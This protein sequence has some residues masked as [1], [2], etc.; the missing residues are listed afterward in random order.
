[1]N[2][3]RATI[4]SSPYIGIFSSVTDEVAL[5]PHSVLPQELRELERVME[6]GAIKSKIGNCSLIGVLCKGTGKKFVVSNIAE[7]GEIRELEKNGIET[8]VLKTRSATGNLVVMNS[9][10][11]VASPLLTEKDMDELKAF[12]GIKFAQTPIGETNLPGAAITV[13]NKGFIV[14]PN[15]TEKEFELL[16]KTFGVKGAPTS[17]NYGDLFVG[18]SVIANSKGAMAGTLTSGVELSRIDDALRG[19]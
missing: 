2:F 9:Q 15:I 18:N 3:S 10:G 7:R 14:H 4:R 1:M 6:V 19:D 13:T 17:A 11:G 12:F 8:M 5:V 16:E